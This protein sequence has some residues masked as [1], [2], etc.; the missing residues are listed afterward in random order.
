MQQTDGFISFW[1]WSF[2]VVKRA[3]GAVA[4]TNRSIS[5]SKLSFFDTP[6]H[7][8]LPTLHCISRK[9]PRR[10]KV[11]VELVQECSEPELK[12][13]P[14][15]QLENVFCCCFLRHLISGNMFSTE[16]HHTDTPSLLHF[17]ARY[18]LRCVA[19]LLLQCP[20]AERALHTA[21]PHSHTPAEVAKSHGHVELHVLL[22]E[23]M[24]TV[25]I[26]TIF[27]VLPPAP[28]SLLTKKVGITKATKSRRGLLLS[29]NTP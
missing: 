28:F 21:C 15:L 6:G 13:E 10:S 16:L 12:E 3:E 8:R 27:L 22:K 24:V 17:A 11:K 5:A 9:L 20:G 29:H 26:F 7:A 14:F 2:T 25:L 1:H 19:G 4:M 23:A 18:G